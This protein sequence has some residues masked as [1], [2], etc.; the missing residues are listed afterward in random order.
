MEAILEK[1]SLQDQQVAIASLPY[2]DI[3]KKKM[4]KKCSHVELRLQE[5][6]EAVTIPRKA[7]ELLEFILLS[8]AEGKTVSLIPSDS[9][10]STQQAAD[11]LNVSRPHLV[12]LL[13]QGAIPFKKVGSHRRVQLEHLL[14]YEQQQ[15]QKQQEHLQ[16]LAQQA[17]ELNLG[18]E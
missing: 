7:L 5:N 17:Q 15:S 8:M 10:L 16:F 9:E 12:K 14:S 11:M 13:E 2:F 18:Y 4:L 3:Y 6:D 1:P